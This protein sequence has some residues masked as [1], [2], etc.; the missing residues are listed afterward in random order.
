MLFVVVCLLRVVVAVAVGILLLPRAARV[1][2]VR[3]RT[4]CSG[5]LVTAVVGVVVV[6]AMVGATVGAVPPLPVFTGGTPFGGR[7][8]GLRRY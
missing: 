5:R 2:L 1:H 8:G 3:L 7:A 4:R 6:G